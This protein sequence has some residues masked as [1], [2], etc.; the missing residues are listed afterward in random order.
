MV[1]MIVVM[2]DAIVMM[3]VVTKMKL[4]EVDKMEFSYLKSKKVIS[5][6]F[7]WDMSSDLI[8]NF[9]ILFSVFNNLNSQGGQIERECKIKIHPRTWI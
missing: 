3:M 8:L 9:Q 2:R 1:K 5:S 7:G 4:M 6:K